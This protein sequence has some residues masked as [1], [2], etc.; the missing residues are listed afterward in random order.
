MRRLAIGVAILAAGSI[1]AGLTL[2]TLDPEPFSASST[3]LIAI[4]I[5]GS[6][7]VALSGFLLVRAP[8]GRWTLVGA[9]ASAA[10]LGT[11]NDGAWFYAVLI[12]AAVTVVTL[13]GPWLRFWVRQQPVPDAPNRSVIVLMAIAPIAPLVVGIGA[14]DTSHPA[15][16][17]AAVVATMGSFLYARGFPGSLWVLRLGLPVAALVATAVSPMPWATT[18]LLAGGVGTFAAWLPDAAKATANPPA[19]LPAPRTPRKDT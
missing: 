4:G 12:A 17:A 18:I 2:F 19:P 3:A 15:Q 13:G 5:L 8:W 1:T 7:L 10:A 6:S 9:V 16:W 14:F 11:A